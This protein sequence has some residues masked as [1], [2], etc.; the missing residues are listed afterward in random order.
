MMPHAATRTERVEVQLLIVDYI[1][2][3]KHISHATY[4]GM[5]IFTPYTAI[6]LVEIVF[7][8]KLSFTI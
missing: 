7:L 4:E 2:V 3:T 6:W 1:Y 8:N 5:F